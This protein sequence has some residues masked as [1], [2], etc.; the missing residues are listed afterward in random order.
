M[1]VHHVYSR[2]A[3]YIC[4]LFYSNLQGGCDARTSICSSPFENDL[5]E[6]LTKSR[7]FKQVL[8][9]FRLNISR[10]CPS[11]QSLLHN[12]SPITHGINLN[13]S[14]TRE[15]RSFIDKTKSVTT[16]QSVPWVSLK[17]FKFELR[18]YPYVNSSNTNLYEI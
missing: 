14:D 18:F 3:Q 13:D 16:G 5:Q 8:C 9:I 17:T 11:L 1:H 4:V 2:I 15:G 12:T 10:I 6:L 7:I